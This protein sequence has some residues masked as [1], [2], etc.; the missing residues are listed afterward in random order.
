MRTL[1]SQKTRPGFLILP[2]DSWLGVVGGRLLP[3]LS[4]DA[5]QRLTMGLRHE[6]DD[7]PPVLDAFDGDVT[8]PYPQFL[9]DLLVDGDLESLAD[10]IRHIRALWYEKTR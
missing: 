5:E 8:R 3:G 6:V 2:S 9:P 4:E 1:E 7:E 10:D